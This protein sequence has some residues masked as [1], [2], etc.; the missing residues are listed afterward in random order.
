MKHNQ[1]AFTLIELLVVV[2]IIGILA[3]VALPQYQK[4]VEKAK[5]TQIVPLLR[6]IHNAQ[7][8]YHLTNGKYSSKFDELTVNIPWTGH[9]KGNLDPNITDT[10]SDNDWSVQIYS[11]SDKLSVAATRLTGR[12]KGCGFQIAQYDS[13]GQ[14][15]QRVPGNLECFERASGTYSGS[16][17][18]NETDGNYCKKLFKGQRI[19]S[20][21]TRLYRLD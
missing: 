3:A 21:N 6:A 18:F 4:A 10:L 2:L 5:A 16:Y 14:I 17:A 11:K 20:G 9:T 15:P 7:E 1:R 19:W 8:A 13:S 12:Y